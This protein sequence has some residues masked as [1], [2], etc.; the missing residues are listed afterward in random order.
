M[1]KAKSKAKK[2]LA[3]TTENSRVTT[4]KPPT[5]LF[6]SGTNL[7]DSF[8]EPPD[9]LSEL[10]GANTIFYGLAHH[11]HGVSP[12]YPVDVHIIGQAAYWLALFAKTV[13]E[14]R[15]NLIQTFESGAQQISPQF[16]IVE[17]CDQKV[18]KYFVLLGVGMKSRE[19]IDA[20]LN[21][22]GTESGGD[23]F[24]VFMDKIEA[25]RNLA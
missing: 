21:T 1:A 12:L 17:K 4:V 14:T 25:T 23:A 19:A 13:L 24:S 20:F 22:Q 15:G 7:P 5:T 16:Q 11:C 10:P 9:Y 6:L 2:D 8:S 3:G 18:Q